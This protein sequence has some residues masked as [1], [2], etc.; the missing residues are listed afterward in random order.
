MID[1]KIL[2]SLGFKEEQAENSNTYVLSIK[3]IKGNEEIGKIIYKPT[4]NNHIP[5]KYQGVLK[6]ISNSDFKIR[7]NGHSV[8]RIKHEADL[9]EFI[10]YI[11]NMI[12]SVEE[13]ALLDTWK[14]NLKQDLEQ[15]QRFIGLLKQEF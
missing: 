6:Y 1:I 9:N 10:L 7:D 12:L 4:I 2:E 5:T 13:F 8:K 15:F 14:M 11:I 3:N